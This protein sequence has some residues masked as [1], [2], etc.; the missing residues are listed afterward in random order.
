[1]HRVVKEHEIDQVFEFAKSLHESRSADEGVDPFAAEMATW[2]AAWRR[3]SLQHYLK[4]GW[5]MACWSQDEKDL[6]GFSLGQPLLFYK[7][8]T[9]TLW[10]EAIVAVD[11]QTELELLEVSYKWARDKHL[12]NLALNPSLLELA[13]ISDYTFECDSIPAVAT[14]KIKQP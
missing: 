7:G 12:Q 8:L 3:E 10:V 13:Q 4:L 11:Q 1:M 2:N 6:L 9:Q 14:A 5:S